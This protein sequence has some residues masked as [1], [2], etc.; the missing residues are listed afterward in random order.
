MRYRVS[1][2]KD[3]GK[4]YADD[5]PTRAWGYAPNGRPYAHLIATF[6]F[7]KKD[8]EYW[9]GGRLTSFKQEVQRKVRRG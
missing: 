9:A 3:E 1:F 5:K 8:I 4:L 7:D 2:T 6:N